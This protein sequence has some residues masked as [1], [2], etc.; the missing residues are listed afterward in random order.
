ML[1]VILACVHNAGRSQMAAAFFNR[2]ADPRK[3]HAVP[4]GTEQGTRVHPGVLEAKPRK[5]TDELAQDAQL[6]V[7]MCGGDKCPYV[8]GLRRD[9]WPL[10]DPKG[11][12]LEHVR[13]IRDEIRHRVELLVSAEGLPL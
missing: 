8:P 2:L 6:Q 12:S 11:L 4:A 5:I 3:D 10:Q 1:K 7:T 9:D 13:A